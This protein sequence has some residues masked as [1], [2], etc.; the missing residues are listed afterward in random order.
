MKTVDRPVR[1]IISEKKSQFKITRTV[2]NEL[3]KKDVVID[4]RDSSDSEEI[5]IKPVKKSSKR[6]SR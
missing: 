6:R 2:K 1:E 4:T 5:E 3:S